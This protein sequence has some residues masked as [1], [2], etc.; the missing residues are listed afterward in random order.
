M[1]LANLA[2]ARRKLAVVLIALGGIVCSAI[3]IGVRVAR[4][5]ERER[6]PAEARAA[7]RAGR[8]DE[9]E[10]ALARLEIHR[11][12]QPEEALLRAES[13][14]AGGRVD[15]ALALLKGIPDDSPVAAQARLLQGRIELRRK[16]AK[17]AERLFRQALAID[18][19]AVQARRE[20]IYIYAF[21]S[22]RAE[23]AAEFLEI[24]KSVPL[25]FENVFHW[26]LTRNTVWEP[27]ELAR[28]LSQWL[29][30]EPDD[31]AT[32]LALAEALRQSGRRAEA[33][34]TLAPLPLDDPAALAI[35][36]RMALD[37]GESE[38][39][40]KLMKSGPVENEELAVLRGRAA[41]ARRDSAEAVRQFTL[42]RRFE[43]D[44]RDAV[45]GLAAA[46][47]QQGDR[48]RALPLLKAAKA[49]DLLATLL[50]RAANPE[51]RDDVGLMRALGEQ[52]EAIGR[53]PEARA[54]YGLAIQRDPLDAQAQ[55]ALFRLNHAPT[56]TD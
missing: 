26:C 34:K 41:L 52:C 19:R 3:P 24:Q 25:T 10:S 38:T 40:E 21:Q 18:P 45:T 36:I 50:A 30:A 14:H 48:A 28:D 33:E 46:L 31:L 7:F 11:P 56:G 54:W 17:S 44:S 15:A 12:L 27:R 22:R 42:A 20:L 13:A 16:H 9:V 23:L 8:F 43:P 51:A 35:K 32:R 37:R 29:E 39:A 6:L 55:K 4:S 49:H 53:T 2:P 5:R 1:I 47:A